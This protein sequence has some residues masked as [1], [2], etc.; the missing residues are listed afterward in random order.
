MASAPAI[1]ATLYGRSGTA[2]TYAPVLGSAAPYQEA[3]LNEDQLAARYEAVTGPIVSDD[4]ARTFP[5]SRLE[6]H[7][8]ALNPAIVSNESKRLVAADIVTLKAVRANLQ[9]K[10][11]VLPHYS[12]SQT[13][14]LEELRAKAEFAGAASHVDTT[15]PV[16]RATTG[17]LQWP[18]TE[19]MTAPMAS[20]A[21]GFGLLALGVIGYGVSGAAATAAH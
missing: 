15:D 1:C 16:T 14:Y 9:E 12:Q 10:L 8:T 3:P 5:K 6:C 13:T 7:R 18:L 4:F 2:A 11:R 19:S 20:I 17:F 21:M